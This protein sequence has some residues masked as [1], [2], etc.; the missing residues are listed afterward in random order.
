MYNLSD[1]SQPKCLFYFSFVVNGVGV[2]IVEKNVSTQTRTQNVA[3]FI[4]TF[5]EMM[6]IQRSS[7]SR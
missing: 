4:P 3:E 6:K 7:R 2:H 5:Y 1:V